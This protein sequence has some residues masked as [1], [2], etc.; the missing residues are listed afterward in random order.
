MCVCVCVCVCV[1]VR[2]CM[3]AC[4]RARACVCVTCHREMSHTVP[5]ENSEMFL[6]PKLQ[7]GA[8]FNGADS[9]KMSKLVMVLWLFEI[10]S[11]L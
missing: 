2:V 11:N 3:C 8:V 7:K 1:R 6:S 9:I 10:G 5:F 4:A